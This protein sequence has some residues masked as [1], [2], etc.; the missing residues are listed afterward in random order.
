MIP[1][2]AGAQAPG[3]PGGNA[4]FNAAV[5]RLFG[6][7]PVF[8]AMVETALT[9][10]TDKSR[11]TLPMQMMKREDRFRIE[12]DFGK[13]KGTGVALQGLSALQNIG[14]SRMASLV[15]PQDKG[16]TIL[17]PELKFQTRVSLSEADLPSA[18]FGLTKKPLG[19]ETI[20]G[21]PCVRNLVTLTASDGTKTEVTTWESQPLGGFP[22]RML[23]RQDD[24]SMMMTF[25]AVSLGAPSE[26]LFKVPGDYRA[27]G[28][29]A[30][31]MQE[32]MTRAVTGSSGR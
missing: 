11:L 24:G 6:D 1:F 15:L 21:Q 8:S 7:I 4:G 18:G 17:F 5:A 2:W 19:K 26:E 31:L 29:M 32:A 22:V 25:S 12:V 3:M 27:F 23:F 30:G 28:S 10:Q 16:M 14:M 13:M 20:Q 9:N